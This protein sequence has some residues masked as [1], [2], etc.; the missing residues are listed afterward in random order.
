MASSDAARAQFDRRADAYAASV[1]HARGEDLDIV[2]AYAAPE[3]GTRALDLATG[4]G[5]TAARIA[6]DVATMVAADV[7]PRMVARAQAL[8]A[9]RGLRNAVAVVAEADR[10]PFADGAFDLVLCH[11]APHHFADVELAVR[12]V[13][14]VLAPGGAF[15]LEDTCSPED[16]ELDGFV[17]RVERLRDPTH[18]HALSKSEW[19]AALAAAGLRVARSETWRKRHDIADWLARADSDGDTPVAWT[20]D[21]VIARAEKP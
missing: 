6:P 2:A 7:A 11:I 3:A 10:L 4:P 13:A 9:E 18:V 20:D 19:R 5:N 14:R 1:S 15:V 8:F 21:K 12:E 17:D 16:P